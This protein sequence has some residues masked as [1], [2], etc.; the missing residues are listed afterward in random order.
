M[1]R[2]VALAFGLMLCAVAGVCWLVSPGASNATG[3]KPAAQKPKQGYL[4]YWDQNEEED[5]YASATGKQ[6]QLI[7]PWDPNGQMC[8]LHDG[9]GRFVV[10]YNPTVPEQH[11]PGGLKP[12][13]QPPI[14][15]ELI[16]RHG[17][18]TGQTLY[19]PGPFA[20]PGSKIGGDSPPDANGQF[21]GQSTYTGCAVDSHHNVLAN[22]IGTAQGLFPVPDDGRL[23]EWFAP[24]YRTYCIVYGPD[25]GGVGP[26]HVDGHGG[27][28]QPGMMN[29]ASNGDLLLPQAGAPSGLGGNVLRF[30]H[31]SL[32]RSAADCPGGIYPRSKVRTSV[33]FQGTADRMPF[34]MAIAHDPTCNCWAVDTAFGDPAI[35]WVDNNGQPVANHPV[36]PGEALAQLGQNPNGFN[37]FGMVFAPDGT[38]YFIDIHIE[39]K[40]GPLVDCGTA[41][42][43]GRVLRVRFANGVPSPP[44]TLAS[45][46][47]F[48]TSVTL[49]M[50]SKERC[51][52]P[53]KPTPPP[54]QSTAAGG[55][56]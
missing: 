17:K 52:F 55:S 50:P 22:D 51:P 5:Y 11:N 14:G 9:T 35:E 4:V 36:I 48:P 23:V 33:F 44:E 6:G 46:F 24:S 40:G 10:G 45:G 31:T 56:G 15:E 29:L 53:S 43:K 28:L 27:L 37:P 7:P 25:S 1:K 19:V 3:I 32:P 26:H 21:N 12:Y 42:G 16:D 8:L 41:D 34:P 18:F 47:S 39:C 49:C 13:K 30:D 20:F 38:L 54:S 2:G